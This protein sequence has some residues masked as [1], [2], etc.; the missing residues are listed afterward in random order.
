MVVM[1]RIDRQL[2]ET[3]LDHMQVKTAAYSMGVSDFLVK[4]NTSSAGFTVT[5]PSVAEA[6]GFR[7]AVKM[8]TGAGSGAVPNA[9]TVTHKSDS[10][11]WNGNVVLRRPGQL[12]MFM[13]DGEQWHRMFV[14]S[15]GYVNAD[16][17]MHE[18]FLRPVIAGS[19]GVAALGAPTGTTG[20]ENVIFCASGNVFEYHILGTQTLLGPIWVDPGLNIGM[21]QTADDGVELCPGIGTNTPHVFTVGTDPAFFARV[22]FTIA[23]VSGTDDC[24]FGFRKR[25]AYQ[26]AIDNYDEM[27]CLNV[28]SGNIN[29]ETILNGAATTTTDTTDDWADAATHSLAVFVSAAGVVTYQIDDAAPST[30]AA[31][32]FDDAEVVIPFFYFLHAADLAGAV[33]I[34]EYECGYQN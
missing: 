19:K 31:F 22:R 13:S 27:A 10:V 20:N 3:V 6:T 25:E 28:I 18:M 7:Y 12:A 30:T 21:N 9:L 33:T 23:D 8:T 34:L 32:T 5:L 29:I 15:G 11:R 1:N 14:N 26:A 4:C 17:Y 16:K 2:Q 24:A